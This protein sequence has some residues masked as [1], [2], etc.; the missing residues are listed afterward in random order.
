MIVTVSPVE[1]QKTNKI[2][3]EKDWKERLKNSNK[4]SK[5]KNSN[6]NN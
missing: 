3:D 6:S 2:K 4:S 5:D 1:F